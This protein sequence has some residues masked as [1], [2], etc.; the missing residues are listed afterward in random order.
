M[1]NSQTLSWLA[2]TQLLDSALPIGGFSHSFGLETMVQEGRIAG[3]HQ[4]QEYIESMLFHSWAPVDAL[5]VKAVYTL[6][7]EQRW[8]EL[9]LV[10]KTQHVQR[11]AM[12]TRDGAAKMGRRLYQLV[13]AMYPQLGWEP[14]NEAVTSGKCIGTHPL[15]HGWISL[16]LG[17][18]L[19][20]AAEGYLYAS[21]MTCINSGLR[22][23]SIGQTDGQ[24]LLAALVPSIQAAWRQCETLDPIEDG[25]GSVPY[26]DI[27][28]M[29][30]ESL[31][32]RLFM[33]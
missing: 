12:E 6:A 30:H 29:R 28:M 11:A 9:W 19:T 33:S 17:I 10:D 23:M 22:L 24:R 18:P 3:L 26:A 1:E 20:M 27:A 4:L 21:A 7:P 16:R 15:I 14:L 13:R 2:Y 32:S 25:F 5:A 8:E 31:Y